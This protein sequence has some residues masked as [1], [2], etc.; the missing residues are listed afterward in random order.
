M[1]P[2]TLIGVLRNDPISDE[3]GDC[4]QY[5]DGG[6]MTLATDSHSRHSAAPSHEQHLFDEDEYGRR[7]PDF[8]A[9]RSSAEFG[10]LRRRS[11]RFVFPMFALVMAWYMTFVLLAAYAHG[12]MAT[13]V[14]GLINMGIVLG[15]AQFLSTLVVMLLYCRYAKRRLDPALEAVRARA[16][17]AS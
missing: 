13:K 6:R 15:L 7:G 16:G 8:A 14:L 1:S 2:P 10:A 9:I 12:F 4:W 5:S 11:R 17:V 3:R